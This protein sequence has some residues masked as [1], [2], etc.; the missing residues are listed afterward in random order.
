MIQPPTTN[1]NY[2]AWMGLPMFLGN[3]WDAFNKAKQAKASAEQQGIENAL[4]MMKLKREAGGAGGDFNAPAY[5]S[6]L[7][8]EL[9]SKAGG[10]ETLKATMNSFRGLESAM[11]AGSDIAILYNFIKSLDPGSVVREGEV[12][13]ARLGIPMLDDAARRLQNAMKTGQT[14]DLL[15]PALRN[16]MRAFA[17][18]D[19]V[20][21]VGTY[22]EAENR[23][24][25]MTEQYSP[26][27]VDVNRVIPGGSYLKQ[28]D[29]SPSLWQRSMERAP[30]GNASYSG[31]G[32]VP[33][34]VA[35]AQ[36]RVRAHEERKKREQAAGETGVPSDAGRY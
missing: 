2:G 5:E 27:G 18:N 28:E 11:G 25:Q 16:Q 10:L 31:P 17:E 36:E 26:F 29:F 19:L 22:R 21:R 9:W 4:K 6:K 7:R 15:T 34:A 1:T 32:D 20:Q 13:L 8:D 30:M 3:A 33:A 23:I 24:R 12:A 35:A 14:S